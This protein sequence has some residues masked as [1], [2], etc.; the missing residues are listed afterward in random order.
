MKPRH[1]L[2]LL[3]LVPLVGGCAAY[4]EDCMQAL[5]WNWLREDYAVVRE[6]L[7]KKT[8]LGTPYQEVVTVVQR[9][10]WKREVPKEQ[11]RAGDARSL[12]ALLGH[13][14]HH[15]RPGTKGMTFRLD[16]YASWHF[17]QDDRL[18]D[19]VVEKKIVSGLSQ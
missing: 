12:T 7:L 2:A 13:Y 6:S 18:A 9:K 14:W 11:H 8:R 3:A 17:G 16:V 19:V 4:R 5:G 1:I 15:R 10:G